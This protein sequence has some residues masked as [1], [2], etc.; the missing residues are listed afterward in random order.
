MDQIVRIIIISL[1]QITSKQKQDMKIFYITIYFKKT[2]FVTSLLPFKCIKHSKFSN[3]QFK[4]SEKKYRN[5]K[6]G[7]NIRF[8]ML[9]IVHCGVKRNGIN[10]T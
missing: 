2:P 4:T 8:M 6:F 7:I 1:Q 3:K 5:D 9:T 10:Q